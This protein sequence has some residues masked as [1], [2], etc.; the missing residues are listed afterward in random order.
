MANIPGISGYTQPGVFARDRVVSTGVSIPGGV[1]I[2]CI[3]GEG[4]K[5]EVL[6]EAAKGSGQDGVAEC[7]PTGE[8]SGKFFKIS[9][10][11]LVT[12]RT[13]LY[14]NGVFLAGYEGAISETE[15]EAG[16]DFRLDP[17][18]GCLELKGA[19]LV[20]QN[21]VPDYY[22]ASTSNTGDGVIQA[23]ELVDVNA[24]TERWT[25][26][27]VSNRAG[28]GGYAKFT[29]TGSVSGQ[30]K[31]SAGRPVLFSS[32]TNDRDDVE[33]NGVLSFRI[34]ES[35]ALDTQGLQLKDSVM[36]AST[37]DIDLATGG[38][39][40]IDGVA[41]LEGQR[42]LV[43]NQDTPSENGIYIV[44]A[45]SWT[46]ASDANS[47]AELL[48]MYAFVEE[49][50]SNGGK[51]F[52]LDTVAP[53]TVGSTSLVFSQLTDTYGSSL[54]ER[55]DKFYVDVE[56]RV[57]KQNDRLVARY[58]SEVDVNDP[59][60]FTSM[61]ALS[62]K[63]GVPSVTNTLSLGAQMAFENGAPAVLALQC[64][65]AIARRISTT[66][67]EEN[68]GIEVDSPVLS[69]CLIDIPAPSGLNKGRPGADTQV[70]FFIVRD[71]EET[72]IFPSKVTF[73][74]SGLDQG[75]FI[76]DPDYDYSYTVVGEGS[77][78]Q[79]LLHEEVIKS[80]LASDG[81]RISYIDETDATFFDSNWFEAFEKLEAFDCQMV[82]PLP[83]QNKSA[84]FNAAV[85][86][87]E[88]MSTIAIQKERMAFFGAMRGVTANALLGLEQ[89][90]VEDVG[91]L[92]GIQGDDP[93]EVTNL[94]I[95]DLVNMKLSDNYNTNRGVYMFPDEII[96]NV[97]GSNVLL[98]GFYM[99]AAAAGY[100][101]GLQNVA[102][103][104]T[105]KSLSGF[106]IGRNK[107]FR[108]T[109]L[110]SLGA[111]GAT[112]VEPVAGGGRVLAGR[113]VSQSGFVEDEEIS[114]M[115]IRDRVKQ[116]LRD[117]LRDF[118]GRQEDMNTKGLMSARA[119]S[120]LSAMISQ[121]LISSFS[122]VRVEKD[123]VDPRQYNVYLRFSPVYPINYV[124]I[125]IEVGVF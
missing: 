66:L 116:N 125:D 89:V 36:A 47:S 113:T 122:N 80:M 11:P 93:E 49:G 18:T 81:L 9:G 60:L 105:Y 37:G 90:A 35:S 58:I 43:K 111:A 38:E 124:F 72:Q 65:P 17:A 59:E 15:M 55:G 12:G 86:H 51:T 75:A 108:P 42:V 25:F 77:P 94:N 5:E 123:K 32:T 78:A 41:L 27:C 34:V 102:V 56:S 103:P 112:V 95:E 7:S 87:C 76:S 82:V 88:T 104:L 16:F 61:K 64:K 68:S 109:I 23:L 21:S 2:A 118:I 4:L 117:A 48:A 54:F 92:E 8:A 63:H 97:N 28:I 110:N 14:L 99:A 6:V 24:P 120:V 69:D 3:M 30:I 107:I 53:I 100:L 20:A 74:D 26:N 40:T 19:S 114:V 52:K 1:R 13:E 67:I 106:S 22:S 121:G 119:I 62:D 31:D 39:L 50:T 85:K 33:S 83:T 70:N 29:L 44:Q 46:R 115:F 91:I 57:L 73:Y 98:D 10:A 96:R 101:S 71:G 79:V 84:I 45:D